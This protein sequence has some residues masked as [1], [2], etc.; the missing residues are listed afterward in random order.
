MIEQLRAAFSENAPVYLM[1]GGLTVG[2]AFGYIVYRMNFCTMGAIS[3]FMNFADWRRFRAWVLS[4]AVAILGTQWLAYSGVLP[5]DKTMY[6]SPS[7]NWVGNVLGGMLFGFGMVFAGGCASRNLARVGGG[8]VRSLLT[9]VVMGIV[10]YMAIGG[11]LGP[12][13]AALEGATSISLAGLGPSQG[14]G[15]IFSAASGSGRA[16]SGLIVGGAVATLLLVYVFSST[17]FRASPMHV[18]SGIGVGICVVA[19]WAITGLAFDELADTPVAPISLTYVRPAGDTLEWLQRYTALGLPG[20]GVAS[21]FGAL[22]GSFTAAWSMGRFQI[23]TFSDTGDTLRN[24]FGATLM[25]IGGVMALGCTVGQA[26]TGV[27]TLAIG[28]FLTFAAIVA[29]GVYGM[30]AFERIVMA[31]A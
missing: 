12:A 28:S 4:A 15:D 29:G 21:V 7:L 1:L 25:G 22:L 26:V 3:D 8:D 24:L 17:A 9:L 18:W 5:L 30:K 6:L 13:R 2:F 16:A 27:S 20:F 10:G 19:G 14:L 31:E 11:V 23:T